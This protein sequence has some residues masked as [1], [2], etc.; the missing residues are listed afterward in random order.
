MRIDISHLA[1]CICSRWDRD[2]RD[3]VNNAEESDAVKNSGGRTAY[4]HCRRSRAAGRV[5]VFELVLLVKAENM[6]FQ[7][8]LQDTSMNRVA[9]Q[10]VYIIVPS[11]KAEITNVVQHRP[12]ERI[13]AR[14]AE[15]NFFASDSGGNR[16]RAAAFGSGAQSTTNRA[17]ELWTS[18]C[19]RSRRKLRH[20]CSSCSA[21]A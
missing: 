21:R 14:V 17:G 7:P 1:F 2:V 4:A 8:P 16:G 12:Q 18:S 13:Q 3:N 15:Q 20:L 9:E 19:L 6:A 10:S 11:A 5:E